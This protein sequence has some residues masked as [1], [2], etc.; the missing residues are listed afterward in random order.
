M[1]EPTDEVFRRP[2][3]RRIAAAFRH[4]RPD[5]VPNFEVLVDNPTLRTIMGRE[6]AGGHTLANID[7]AD[8]IEFVRRIGQDVVGMCFYA[9]PFRYADAG[10]NV[11]G[12]D[13]RIRD[14]GDIRRLLPDSLEPIEERFS[15]LEKYERAVAGT[16]VGLFVLMGSFLCD[17]YTSVF[18][19]EDFMVMLYDQR[20]LIEEVLD[21]YTDFY[22]AMARRLVQYDLT[23]FY[24]GDDVGFKSGTLVHPDLLREMWIP[25]MKRI[26]E[27]AVERGIP[28]LFHSDGN[29]EQIIP[30]LIEIGVD[31]LNP[32]EPYGM[33]I[34]QIKRRFG[35]NLTLVG[36][37][38]VGGHLSRGTTRQVYD[39]ACQLID[40]VG[41]DG[42][43]VLA[44][45]HSIT[46]NVKPENFLAMVEAA[47]THRP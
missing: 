12:L 18:G 10:G 15:L 8:Y 1:S 43:L 14:E 24:A 31:A 39:E 25:R 2:D 9:S 46:P 30:D 36:N 29:I 22:V 4:E 45:S 34:R 20:D 11:R 5:R 40:D 28:I 7:P 19:F 26:L 41:A 6:V 44:S 32:I 37:L 13:F 3:K 35:R 23:F 33:D 17:A 27:P 47:Q 38:D 16:D 42:G 21:R